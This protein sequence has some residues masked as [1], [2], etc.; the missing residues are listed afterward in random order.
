MQS[1]LETNLS[2]PESPLERE[3]A[4]LGP[5]FHNIH[6]PDGT[7]TAPQHPLGDFP[8]FKWEAIR[9][10]IPDNFEGKTVLDIG[11]NAGFY[12]LK[13]AELGAKVTAIDIDDHYLHQ[14]VWAA[15]KFKAAQRIEF[16]KMQVY[17]LAHS[18]NVYDVVLFMG[19][20]YHLR[21]PLLALDI[22]SQQFREFMLFQSMTIPGE[23]VIDPGVDFR[24]KDRHLMLDEGWP[25]MAF[26]ENALEGDNTN[27]WVPNHSAIQAMLRSV[28]IAVQDRPGHEIYLCRRSSQE[29]RRD[30]KNELSA[31]VEG[32][33]I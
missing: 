20:F 14:A 21:H 22:V 17:E 31:A 19:V 8:N 3:I 18:R 32:L 11:C 25:K 4:A 28:G 29:M 24:M 9:T 6:L 16:K 33:A 10:V 23:K 30:I 13:F 2:R 7:Q 12:S 1:T 26:I 27:W 15:K 5:W